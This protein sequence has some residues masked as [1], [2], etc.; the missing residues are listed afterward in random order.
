[1][2]KKVNSTSACIKNDLYEKLSDFTWKTESCIEDQ[3][4]QCTHCY[5]AKLNYAVQ[6]KKL[7]MQHNQMAEEHANADIAHCHKLECMEKDIEWKNAEENCFTQQV[8]M[9]QLQIQLEG[10][11]CQWAQSSVSR[12]P[13]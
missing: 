5:I 2:G 7:E 1:M 10:L 6:D 13:A 4:D 9:L 11:Q 12:S 8:E 3:D